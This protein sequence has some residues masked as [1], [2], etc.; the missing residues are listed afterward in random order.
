MDGGISDLFRVQKASMDAQNPMA[1]EIGT[2]TSLPPQLLQL[3]KESVANQQAEMRMQSQAAQAQQQP[4]VADTVRQKS[5][6]LMQHQQQQAKAQQ[7]VMQQ[8]MQAQKQPIRFAGGGAVYGGT[9]PYAPYGHGNSLALQALSP[10]ERERL[11]QEYE[12]LDGRSGAPWVLE[13]LAAP[14]K[15][16]YEMLS[17][18]P[19]DPAKGRLDEAELLRESRRG[20]PNKQ[21]IQALADAVVPADTTKTDNESREGAEKTARPKVNPTGGITALKRAVAPDATVTNT[22]AVPQSGAGAWGQAAQGVMAEKA[23]SA[24]E[25]I[26][27]MMEARE[28]YGP[29][30]LEEQFLR[31]QMAKRDA[32]IDKAGAERPGITQLLT[33]MARAARNDP[34]GGWGAGL[35][36]AAEFSQAQA[37]KRKAKVLELQQAKDVLLQTLAKLQDAKASG[38]LQ[39]VVVLQKE[40]AKAAE[41]LANK[42]A[43][44]ATTMG[45]QEM[46]NQGADQRLSKELTSR[47]REGAADRA[48]RLQIAE[49][50]NAATIKSAGMR[51][52]GAANPDKQQLAE[53][54]ALQTQLQAQVKDPMN[55]P[56]RAQL[57]SQL[58]MV[59]NAIAR[60][61]GVELAGP[62]TGAPGGLDLSQWGK[63]QVVK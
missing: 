1:P 12:A 17:E 35:L 57:Q 52:A 3:V 47:E 16:F 24:A 43:Q 46:Q 23:L 30:G 49:G 55:F 56:Q 18:G 41:D 37:K 10:E 38:V 31:D 15:R 42:K 2:S 51:V 8:M 4:T 39:D 6:S 45:A 63:P 58:N 53:L 61:A 36:G 40:A 22:S 20:K 19:Q 9:T 28:K 21:G 60:M 59:N 48:N 14:F 34:K 11:K 54:K 32:E 62:A 13:Q 44:M 26:K 7:D 25:R 27:Q 33:A 29:K 50:N 5:A